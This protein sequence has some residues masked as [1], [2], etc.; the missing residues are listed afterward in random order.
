MQLPQHITCIFGVDVAIV[1]SVLNVAIVGGIVMNLPATIIQTP[2]A[3]ASP[4]LLIITK[5][6]TRVS[7]IITAVLTTKAFNCND[8]NNCHKT[9]TTTTAI[10]TT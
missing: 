3:A 2:F 5:A 7:T 9:V 8:T 6:T 4:T 10:T 1:A